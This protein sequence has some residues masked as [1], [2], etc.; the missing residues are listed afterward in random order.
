LALV[1]GA[2]LSWGATG[3]AASW[4]AETGGAIAVQD[5]TYTP[6]TYISSGVGDP[7]NPKGGAAVRS[8]ANITGVT[9]TGNTVSSFV[10]EITFDDAVAN[11]GAFGPV[12]IV[13]DRA[14][15]M[16]SGTQTISGLTLSDNTT[17]LTADNS[18]D[19]PSALGGGARLGNLPNLNLSGS[20]VSGNAL[21][22]DITSGGA[23]ATVNGGGMA[24]ESEWSAKADIGGTTFSGNTAS[25][26]GAGAG[27]GSAARGGALYLAGA[28]NELRGDASPNTGLN[29]TVSGASVMP[30]FMDNKTENRNGGLAGGGAV[31]A[32]FAVNVTFNQASFVNNAAAS[33]DGD[34]AGGAVR[35]N[36]S[37]YDMDSGTVTSGTLNPLN[38]ASSTLPDY[39][40]AFVGTEFI[41]NSATGA[42]TA[43]G[44]AIWT[45]KNIL[46]SDSVFSGNTANAGKN[47]IHLGYD[48]ASHAEV[49]F[50][51][52]AGK[53]STDYDGISGAGNIIK[54]GAGGLEL[55]GDYTGFTGGY[56]LD[57]GT[58]HFNADAVTAT[59]ATSRLVV[60]DGATVDLAGA[61]TTVNV[62]S[63]KMNNGATYVF[64]V[65]GT[66]AS[67][68][69]AGSGSAEVGQVNFVVRGELRKG[70]SH[71][72]LESG[73]LTFA[74]QE[75]N[76]A[77]VQY[78]YNNVAGNRIVLNVKEYKRIPEIGV[79]RNQRTVGEYVQSRP[80]HP[81]YEYAYNEGD[82]ANVRLA[83]DTNS[84]DVYASTVA[85]VYLHDRRG[86]DAMIDRAQALFLGDAPGSGTISSRSA[87]G[88][89]AVAQSGGPG[90]WAEADGYKHRSDD[91]LNAARGKTTGYGLAVGVDNMAGDWLFGAAFRY[92][93]SRLEV[94]DRHAKNNFD[95]YTLAL[96][97]GARACLGPGVLHVMGGINGAYHTFE[98]RRT[99]IV[100]AAYNNSAAG[101][102][103][104]SAIAYVDAGMTF[105]DTSGFAFQP[106]ATAMWNGYWND[107]VKEKGV[108]PLYALTAK[109]D[110]NDYF[111]TIL[112]VRLMAQ[113]GDN[114][115]VDGALGWR[116]T[117]GDLEPRQSMRF[118]ND[119]AH[120]R[121]TILGTPLKRDEGVFGVGMTVNFNEC[122]SLRGGY[123]FITGANGSLSHEGRVNLGVKF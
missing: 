7:S 61:N 25:V 51:D 72:I 28:N 16:V 63:I 78:S 74:D 75:V 121:F 52:A 40:A 59:G 123:D 92:G 113:L 58:T 111:S 80:A 45:N 23:N 48:G 9:F 96:Y 85:S 1:I 8:G 105:G 99:S 34:A 46:V 12:L 20:T 26:G 37:N 106:Y 3:A 73:T 68:I 118:L 66:S 81:L 114:V 79:T 88:S 82:P 86:V 41:G 13:G 64:D 90:I 33:A 97:G 18:A 91:G 17:T 14:S 94:D 110:Q 76:L 55:F 107:K 6:G 104:K 10:T 27:V 57:E 101:Y 122:V 50:H 5:Q 98:S 62:G 109:S 116:H 11:A 31:N 24:I 100:G 102:D 89:S 108:N 119:P 84:G 2:L 71:T 47:A 70:D 67:K 35:L 49:V 120:D 15:Q 38:F 112:G 43:E 87:Y 77:L 22:A 42:T 30:T 4:P 60:G 53:K 39:Y 19:Y 21:N 69:S 32:E 44:G 83:L 65:D 95:S 29:V 117:F 115:K 56:L 93:D 54:R 36:L 103:G